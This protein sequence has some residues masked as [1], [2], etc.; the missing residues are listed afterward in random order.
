M[1]RTILLALFV[2]LSRSADNGVALLPPM[3][4]R[5]WNTFYA[6]IDDKK[7]R[8][9]IDA[10]V[11]PRDAA[12]TTLFSLG[13]REIGIDEG[14]EGCDPVHYA[15]GTPAVDLTKFPD[16]P[17]LVAYGH[18]KGV[19]MGHYLNGC[20]CNERVEKRINYEGDVRQVV[21][22]GFDGVKIDSCGAQKNMTLYYELF[23]QSGMAL[24]IENCH[25]GRNITDGGDPGQMGP[26]WCP[27]NIFR[28]SGD[29][30][31]LW[32]RVMSNLMTVEP[33][34]SPDKKHNDTNVTRPVSGPGCWAYPD[35][36]EVG[37][38][39]EH[40]AA[41]SRSHFAAWAL[42]SAPLT[43]G[44]DLSDDA[45]LQLAWP[46]IS[47]RDVIAI[48][49]TWVNGAAYPSGRLLKS[50]QATNAPTLAVR[51]GCGKVACV[52]EDP[53]CAAWAADEQCIANPGWMHSHCARSCGACEQGNS[54]SWA[55]NRTSGMLTS[56]GNL[57][58][59]LRGQ[60]PAGHSGGN[61]LHALPCD[62]SQP[63]Q[64]WT[65]NGTGGAI[66]QATG[67]TT[68]A[69][70]ACLQ[71]FSTWLWDDRP[72][73]NTVSS[74]NGA[75]PSANQ[76]WTLFA[77]GTL[78]NG[79]FGC[80]EVTDMQGP[81][82]TVWAKPLD[83]H[84]KVALLAINGADVP[85]HFDLDFAALLTPDVE[86][87]GAHMVPSA[88]QT[89]DVYAAAELGTRSSLARQVEPHDCILLVL[90]PA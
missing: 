66:Q 16:L 5:S 54:T 69:D 47:N 31:N 67:T 73:V 40:N 52:D 36:L 58:L 11:K 27:Y 45:K 63:T 60:L 13:F 78:R 14:W 2:T 65:F 49:Q 61:I 30:V 24:S 22:W 34:L 3:G 48:S 4:W 44:F 85:Q 10:L 64:R 9:Q 77:N 12:G 74:C 76:Q 59:D 33:F 51:G 72:V 7:I 84:G 21:A 39:P 80:I 37:R 71:A 55:Y 43:L 75:A 29:I 90:T 41:E 20:G 35:M 18:S 82:S 70:T 15:N 23:N 32:D 46:I 1:M 25:Q 83:L 68:E 28:T 81:L 38:M 86:G 26:G 19:R 79:Q 89:R 42:V 8:A 50:W 6:D 17:G 87:G 88:W 56:G 62:A 53:K 57:C